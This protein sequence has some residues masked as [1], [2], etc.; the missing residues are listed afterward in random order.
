M[1]RGG[2]G[3]VVGAGRRGEDPFDLSLVIRPG[4]YVGPIC[5]GAASG[6]GVLRHRAP[7]TLRVYAPA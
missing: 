6:E 3:R 4:R 1:R 2:K 5:R 7:L